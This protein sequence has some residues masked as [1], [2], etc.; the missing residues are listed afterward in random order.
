MATELPRGEAGL[1]ARALITVGSAATI[2]AACGTGPGPSQSGSGGGTAVTLGITTSGDGIV[3]ESGGDCRGSCTVQVANGTQLQ[4]QAIPDPGV[5]FTGWSGACSGLSTACP[6]TADADTAVTAVFTRPG[7]V[8]LPPPAIAP[9][10]GS[11]ECSTTLGSDTEIFAK[12][13]K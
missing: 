2:L 6:I 7:P 3:R 5:S 9:C 12:R 4:L 1:R 8:Q 10:S 13:L 11:S